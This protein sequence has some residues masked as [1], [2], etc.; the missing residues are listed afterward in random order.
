MRLSS[1]FGEI[2]VMRHTTKIN[3]NN[4]FS[5]INLGMNSVQERSTKYNGTKIILWRTEDEKIS[6]VFY[7]STQDFN[8]SNNPKRCN[9]ISVCKLNSNINVLY[10]NRCNVIHNFLV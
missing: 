9:G 3:T 2:K 4:F 5:A 8:I 6:R 1:K 10:F 7:F